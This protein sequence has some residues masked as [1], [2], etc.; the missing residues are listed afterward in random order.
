MK[1]SHT[2]LQQIYPILPHVM[3]SACF[4]QSN[5]KNGVDEVLQHIQ[6]HYVQ[7]RVALHGARHCQISGER[8]KKAGCQQG[9]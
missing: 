9:P 5:T 8:V 2:D 7:Q 3:V 1:V 4:D 6:L